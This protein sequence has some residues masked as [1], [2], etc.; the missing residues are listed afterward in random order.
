ML[1]FDEDQSCIPEA[2]KTQCKF[3]QLISPTTTL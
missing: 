3:N 1:S 2:A